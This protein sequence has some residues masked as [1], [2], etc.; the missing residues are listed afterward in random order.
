MHIFLPNL[1]SQQPQLLAQVVL[2]FP[3]IFWDNC[4]DYFGVALEGGP[5]S[6]GRCPIFWN[7]HRWTGKPLLVGLLCGVSADEVRKSLQCSCLSKAA[8]VPSDVP[9]P[10]PPPPRHLAG[11]SNSVGLLFGVSEEHL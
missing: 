8:L 5:P 9:P 10:P 7:A 6:R 11:S 2:E 4:V 3:S 1:R